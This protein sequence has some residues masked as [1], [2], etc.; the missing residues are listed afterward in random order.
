MTNILLNELK[1]KKIYFQYEIIQYDLLI[2]I[3]I[4]FVFF[5]YNLK[6]IRTFALL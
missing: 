3:F 4:L 2:H 5:V 6:I 1:L